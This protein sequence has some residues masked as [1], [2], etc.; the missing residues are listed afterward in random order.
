MENIRSIKTEPLLFPWQVIFL[1][2]RGYFNVMKRAPTCTETIQSI[3]HC[4]RHETHVAQS[5]LL[6]DWASPP[7][8]IADTAHTEPDATRH[9][10]EQHLV[11]S[12]GTDWVYAPAMSFPWFLL[13][14]TAW[15]QSIMLN[16]LFSRALAS[17]LSILLLTWGGWGAAGAVHQTARRAEIELSA[18]E[19]DERRGL[20]GEQRWYKSTGTEL[21]KQM[22]INTRINNRLL[23]ITLFK[24]FI[25]KSTRLCEK[26]QLSKCG[27]NI[28]AAH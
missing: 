8:G 24:L 16:F 11:W 26:W 15:D 28:L 14:F 12:V 5:Q 18:A 22:W 25:N 27:W 1:Q 3:R 13:F 10:L 9:T 7:T 19:G 21:V 4:H 23:W 20:K 6:Q 2:T 17:P